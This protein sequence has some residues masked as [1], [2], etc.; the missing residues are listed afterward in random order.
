MDWS[1]GNQEH[2]QKGEDPKDEQHDLQDEVLIYDPHVI[3][4]LQLQNAL[5]R[6]LLK[7]AHHL[8]ADQLLPFDE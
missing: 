2:H 3:L 7:Q 8:V 1:L 5:Q 6:V 4:V